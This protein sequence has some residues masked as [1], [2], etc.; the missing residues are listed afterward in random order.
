MTVD[1]EILDVITNGDVVE[2]AII[3]RREGKNDIVLK[4][5]DPL[6]DVAKEPFELVSHI[7]QILENYVRTGINSREKL[8]SLTQWTKQGNLIGTKYR[9]E[10]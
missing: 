10:I 6:H 1:V 9:F 2:F 5:T 8:K 4:F 7:S 3:I